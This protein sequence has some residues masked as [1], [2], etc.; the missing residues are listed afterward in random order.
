MKA[1]SVRTAVH[2]GAAPVESSPGPRTVTPPAAGGDDG[3]A[4]R[5]WHSLRAQRVAVGLILSAGLIAS[6]ELLLYRWAAGAL[7]LS[8]AEHARLGTFL[9]TTG[10]IIT[11]IAAAVVWWSA[12]SSTAPLLS[13][14]RLVRG[15]ARQD[16]VSRT[17]VVRKDEIGVMATALNAT[18][19]GMQ[20]AIAEVAGGAERLA[21]ASRRLDDTSHRLDSDA[22]LTAQLATTNSSSAVEVSSSI[23]SVALAVE[24]L[25]SG[26]QEVARTAALAAS[27]ADTGM[28]A[29]DQTTGIV[30]ELGT[31]SADI[32]GIARLIADIAEQ[33]NLL[34]LNA[35][36]EAAR[37]GEAGRGFAVVAGEIK[38][39]A[40]QTGTATGQVSHRIGEMQASVEQATVAL[41]QIVEVIRRMSDLQTTIAAAVEEQAVTTAD[42]G[43]TLSQ[44][45]GGADSIAA[46]AVQVAEAAGA[47]TQ[48][49]GATRSTAAEM[50]A[51]SEQLH[52]LVG[53]FHYR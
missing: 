24:Q 10:A 45:A 47:A 27:D 50:L 15:M 42:I 28:R 44:A 48:S 35:S 7:H 51:L 19:D 6:N 41:A 52:A 2:A 31:R 33:T 8:T 17:D 39:L 14:A 43:R 1:D 5:P 29:A 3:P 9:T 40:H 23:G 22:E 38:D 13:L 53:M 26:V 11:C 46:N 21:Q 30:A 18:L 4:V 32:G 37:A 34:A 16:L 49:A 36:I 20:Q 25:A 12:G